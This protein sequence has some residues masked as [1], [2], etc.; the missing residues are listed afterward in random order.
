MGRFDAG[1]KTD[2]ASALAIVSGDSSSWRTKHLRRRARFLR[3]RVLKGDI[4]MRH[5]PGVEMIADLGTKALTAAKLQE[6]K[7]LLGMMVGKE[8]GPAAGDPR[9]E[10]EAIK[11]LKEKVHAEITDMNCDQ[12]DLENA[13]MPESGGGRSRFARVPEGDKLKLAIVLAVMARARGESEMGADDD[14]DLMVLGFTLL[15]ILIT[16]M[17]TWAIRGR[18]DAMWARTVQA[19]PRVEDHP[20]EGNPDVQAEGETKDLKQHQMPE[21]FAEEV[22]ELLEKQLN[23]QD[24]D[25][26]DQHD[27][28]QRDD[29]GSGSDVVLQDEGLDSDQNAAMPFHLAWGIYVS[30]HGRCYHTRLLCRGFARSSHRMSWEFC[31]ECRELFQEGM[32]LASP[33]DLQLLHLDGAHGMWERQDVVW[34][35]LRPCKI[36]IGREVHWA[37]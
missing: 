16:G 14:A 8:N 12:D 23:D 2:S 31:D 25:F 27:R 22:A 1:S 28:D 32:T 37:P 18:W 15:V 10:T 33:D 9:E 11:V 34:R 35:K 3:W 6:L 5:L 30:E 21:A 4:I 20:I 17:L 19:E 24:E 7:M 29:P 13:G 26:L 36:C